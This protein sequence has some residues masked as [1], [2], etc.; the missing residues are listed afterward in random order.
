MFSEHGPHF[1][2][3]GI[4]FFPEIDVIKIG[5]KPIHLIR[6]EFEIVELLARNAGRTLTHAELMEKLGLESGKSLGSNLISVYVTRIRKKL[7]Y[8]KTILRTVHG[9]GYLLRTGVNAQREES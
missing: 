3:G 6:R 9:K 5:D 8:H 2:A 1:S 7:G 4:E